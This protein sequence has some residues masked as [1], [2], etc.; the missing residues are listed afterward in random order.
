MPEKSRVKERAALAPTFDQGLDWIGLA[1]YPAAR[2]EAAFNRLLFADSHERESHLLKESYEILRGQVYGPHVWPGTLHQNLSE[3]L[4]S[5]L[6]CYWAEHSAPEAPPL[7]R[8]VEALTTQIVELRSRLE[9]SS[10]QSHVFAFARSISDVIATL[11]SDAFGATPRAVATGPSDDPQF[12]AAVTL[13]FE[14]EDLRRSGERRAR[15]KIAFF[16]RLVS[17]ITQPELDE[18]DFLFRFV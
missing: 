14:D 3:T 2:S 15:S 16:E 8:Q 4:Q 10:R 1:R 6:Y 12:S 13:T 5:V 18:V 17:R 7:V 9:R 11:A